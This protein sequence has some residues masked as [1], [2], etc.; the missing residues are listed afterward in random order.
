[1]TK[2]FEKCNSML[3]VRLTDRQ[4]SEICNEFLHICTYSRDPSR[5]LRSLFYFSFFWK[6]F[7]YKRFTDNGN[8]IWMIYGCRYQHYSPEYCLFYRVS[9]ING[10]FF[11]FKYTRSLICT[12]FDAFY[13]SWISTQNRFHY[14]NIQRIFNAIVIQIIYFSQVIRESALPFDWF[15]ILTFANINRI[16]ILS[17]WMN[18]QTEHKITIVPLGLRTK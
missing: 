5:V 6:H 8:E 17:K 7:C 13:S 14:S 18:K 16:E 2:T 10:I 11:F 9:L 15:L 4:R 1:M 12:V 3:N